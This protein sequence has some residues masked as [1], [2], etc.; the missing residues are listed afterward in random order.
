M[1]V[2]QFFV[3]LQVAHLL[4]LVIA[5]IRYS[6]MDPAYRPFILLLLLGFLN[7]SVN[8]LLIKRL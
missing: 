1:K 4:P 8:Y 5:G 6:R 7:E 2:D 3:I